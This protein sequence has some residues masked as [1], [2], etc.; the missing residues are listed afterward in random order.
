MNAITI[1]KTLTDLKNSSYAKYFESFVVVNIIFNAIIIGLQTVYDNCVLDTLD[2]LCLVLFTIEFT[3]RCI[4]CESIKNIFKNSLLIFD[5][6]I[7]IF[8]C[9][10]EKYCNGLIITPLRII[11]VL[12]IIRLVTINIE[13]KTILKVLVK[14]ISSITH[15]MFLLVIFLYVF[16]IIGVH[17]FKMPV[18]VPDT[19]DPQQIQL[20]ETFNN[21]KENSDGY[22]VG[23]EKD[24]Y[25]NVFES[26]FSLFKII[27]GDDWANMRNNQIIASEMKLIPTPTWVIT[28][29]HLLWVVFGAYLLM[30]LLIGAIINNYDSL[31]QKTENIE[32]D[33]KLISDLINELEKQGYVK[34]V[35]GRK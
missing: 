34:K 22:F 11:R 31:S 30:N 32:K 5:L 23:G 2:D 29:F 6:I 3:I 10:P 8:C 7:L 9:I 4:A 33:K 21:F 28:S 13:L 12:R 20:L 24:P 1:C 35:I 19:T 16:G 26:M 18:V 27:T 14:S 17:L 15:T 25:G